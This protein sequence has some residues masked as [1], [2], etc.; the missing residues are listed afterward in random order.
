MWR[1]S[2]AGWQGGDV[3]GPMPC[4]DE[5]PRR[6]RM[7]W[8]ILSYDLGVE[9]GCAGL[10]FE[11]TERRKGQEPLPRTRRRRRSRVSEG[12]QR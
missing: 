12:R 10:P 4:R 1:G 11:G 6:P 9:Q 3:T 5:D 8:G 7:W 2:K